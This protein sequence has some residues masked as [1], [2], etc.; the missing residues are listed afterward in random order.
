MARLVRV[1]GEHGLDPVGRLLGAIGAGC[2]LTRGSIALE[3]EGPTW[4]GTKEVAKGPRES[5]VALN[6]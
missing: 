6:M 1:A 4:G 2:G 5:L 3:M